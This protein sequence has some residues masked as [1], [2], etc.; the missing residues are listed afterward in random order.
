MKIQLVYFDG[1]A[2]WQRGLKNLEAALQ[3]QG[4]AQSVELIKVSD[5]ADARRLKFLGSPSFRINGQDLW[6]GECKSYS[7]SCRLYCTPQGLKGYPTVSML[8]EALEKF[9][10]VRRTT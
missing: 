10:E 6:S 3:E 4:L 9:K 2:F 7:L 8:K 1:C 5:E